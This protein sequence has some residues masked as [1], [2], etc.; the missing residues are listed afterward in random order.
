MNAGGQ[1]P[2]SP[3][4]TGPQ[5]CGTPVSYN[6]IIITTDPN[7]TSFCQRETVPI[8]TGSFISNFSLCGQY[9]WMMHWKLL[10]TL[11]TTKHTM[12]WTRSCFLSGMQHT[13]IHKPTHKIAYSPVIFMA[14][15]SVWC[16]SSPG[17]GDLWTP[18]SDAF[19][20]GVS[21]ATRVTD[22]PAH[23]GLY[24]YMHVCIYVCTMRWIRGSIEF[25][26]ILFV[27]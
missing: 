6:V 3:A 16:H 18:H 17:N 12:R 10:L 15:K 5:S 22:L 8:A 14:E 23:S 20:P 24:V 27:C 11:T 9:R 2:L 13:H 26:K 19:C 25:I 21:P 7:V 1:S 4:C